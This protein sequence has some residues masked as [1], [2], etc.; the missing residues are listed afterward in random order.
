MRKSICLIWCLFV[1]TVAYSQDKS[2][3]I[4]TDL[5]LFWKAYDAIMN[6]TDS[7]QQATLLQ[8]MYIDKGSPGLKAMMEARNYTVADYLTAIH[9]YPEFWKSIR[10]NML[11]ADKYASEI[12]KG[13]TT[14]KK[15]YP[16]RPAKIYF[17]VGALRS[18]GTTL[19]DKVLIGSEIALADFSTV[20]T[21]FPEQLSH[22]KSYFKL[23]PV[24]DIVF[25]NVHEYVHTQQDTTIGDYLLSQCVLEGVAEFVA[26]KAMGVASPNPPIAFGKANDAALKTAF[27][28][29]MFSPYTNNWLYNS[30][31]NA[32]GM[33]DLGYYM[34]YAICE[35]FYEQAADKKAAI[36]YM[37]ELDYNNDTLLYHF[38]DSS[39]YF[40]KPMT[41]L[42]AA[43][44]ASLP[45][46]SSISGLDKG[47][48]G[49]VAPGK[50]QIIVEF[51]Q[52]MDP[53]YFRS[54]GWGPAGES[55]MM[56]VQK[57][58]GFNTNSIALIVEVDLQPQRHYQ[59][60]IGE[61]FRTKE[62]IPLRKY[63]IDINTGE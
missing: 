54:F 1:A 14:L 30:P 44:E 6:T 32:F 43:Y 57:V 55:A 49:L 61:G 7:N 42:K 29:C 19:Q 3:I 37:I 39:R 23:N 28:K 11:R 45:T 35:K 15:L 13:I 24:K 8:T 59:L 47:I 41:E 9:R 34:G 50:K 56:K 63:L 52:Q 46:V 12:Q 60:L 33:R 58:V 48:T 22:L 20:S 2:P 62:S 21:E 53:K 26:V 27:S 5:P 10:P 36:K 18:G 31:K 17:T 38:V 40:D 16:I 25:Q 4:T 51:S